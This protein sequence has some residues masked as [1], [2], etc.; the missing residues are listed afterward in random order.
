MIVATLAVA[1]LVTPSQSWGQGTIQTYIAVA[2]GQGEPNAV[3]FA[4]NMIASM[5][6][7]SLD[8]VPFLEPGSSVSATNAMT[9]DPNGTGSVIVAGFRLVTADAFLINQIGREAWSQSAANLPGTTNMVTSSSFGPS[10]LG[11]KWGPSGPGEGDIIYT[12]GSTSGVVLNELYMIGNSYTFRLDAGATYQQGLI[13]F[14]GFYGP[15]MTF[16]ARYY[17]RDIS[18]HSMVNLVVPEPTSATV[19]TLGFL[20]F[21]FRQRK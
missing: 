18:S 8:P 13:D 20:G 4:Q 1:L 14:A 16:N 7:S 3:A 5:R 9:F 12:S 21:L 17:L 10:L 15:V 19:V 11:V 2:P 6:G